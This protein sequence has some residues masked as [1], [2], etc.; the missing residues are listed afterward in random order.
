[1]IRLWQQYSC[2]NSGSYRL[3]ARFETAAAASAAADEL[4]ALLEKHGTEDRE[5]RQAGF[6]GLARQ[7]GFD[8]EDDGYGGPAGGPHVIVDH[9]TLIVFHAY[10]TGL[11]PGVPAFL[12]ERTATVGEQSWD[13]IHVSV[14]FTTGTDP[15]LSDELDAFRARV[16]KAEDNIV[17]RLDVPWIRTP[18]RGKLGI[19]RDAGTTGL[20]FPIDP[21]DLAYLRSWLA[22]HGIDNPIVS[23]EPDRDRELFTALARARCTAC[24]GAL[25][26]LDPRL[27]DIETPQLVCRPCGGFYELGAFT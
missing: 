26:Y 3:V 1:M 4:R 7:Y 19:F 2:N 17:E 12:S 16:A 13:A 10:C 27:H 14:L 8:W 18:V 6:E 15:R 11:G 22:E 24:G 5:D 20:V 25:E 21:R 23:I 9:E